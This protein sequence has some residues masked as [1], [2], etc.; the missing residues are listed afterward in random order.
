MRTSVLMLVSVI[1]IV[2]IFVGVD[3]AAGVNTI[4]KAV[5]ATVAASAIF[6]VLYR[7]IVPG[8]S[9]LRDYV[10]RVAKHRVLEEPPS[11]IR[12]VDELESVG[13]G[14]RELIASFKGVMTSAKNIVDNISSQSSQIKQSSNQI[15]TGM[16]QI[17]QAVQEIA[18]SA[19]V[20]SQRVQELDTMFKTINNKLKEMAE[21]ARKVMEM[22]RRAMDTADRSM[23]EGSA[24]QALLEEM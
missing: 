2:A 5:V 15:S 16:Q 4:V 8:L 19:Q 6:A 13:R 11:G 12:G 10:E 24:A 3:A 7:S 18:K 21:E 17:S 14:L 1:A 23:K 22:G 9:A 20:T